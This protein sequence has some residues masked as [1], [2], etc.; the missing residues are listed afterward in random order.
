MAFDLELALQVLLAGA[1]WLLIV[2]AVWT[3]IA[4]RRVRRPERPMPVLLGRSGTRARAMLDALPPPERTTWPQAIR[5]GLRAAIAPQ[6]MMPGNGDHLGHV[7]RS[8]A[9]LRE[10]RRLAEEN[11]ACERN[12]Q[13]D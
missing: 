5:R 7:L 11:E 3:R 10:L 8:E 1:F 4:A 2:R 12:C 6:W 9:E 13:R